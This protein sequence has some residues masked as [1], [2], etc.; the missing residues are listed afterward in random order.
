[1]SES[2]RKTGLVPFDSDYFIFI[3]EFSAFYLFGNIRKRKLFTRT[4]RRPIAEEKICIADF[5]NNVGL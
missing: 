4:M 1:M 2:R 5:P 3:D